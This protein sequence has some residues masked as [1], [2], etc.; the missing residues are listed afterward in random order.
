MID[1]PRVEGRVVVRKLTPAGWVRQ[2]TVTMEDCSVASFL[3][4]RDH[5]RLELTF[6]RVQV[7]Q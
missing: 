5:D 4:D 2:L 1:G 7:D 6:S 3:I